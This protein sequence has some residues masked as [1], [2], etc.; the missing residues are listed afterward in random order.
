MCGLSFCLGSIADPRS[1]R[2]LTHAVLAPAPMAS[3]LKCMEPSFCTIL[4]DNGV[5]TEV[6]AHLEEKKVYSMA[7]LANCVDSRSERLPLVLIEPVRSITG[8]AFRETKTILTEL[9]READCAE[10][11]RMQRK[12]QG[13]AEDDLEDPLPKPIVDGL[14]GKHSKRYGYELTFVELLCEPLLG[15]IKR[16]I[17][18]N[19]HSLIII[20]KV[21]NA[22]ENSR[23]A[24]GKRIKM[25]GDVTVT[26]GTA[27]LPKGPRTVYG[28]SI[29]V[30][31]LEILFLGGYSVVGNFIDSKPSEVY[32]PMQDLREYFVMV[33]SKASPLTGPW[34]KLESVRS[35]D[36]GTRALWAEKM[37]KG[38]TMGQAIRE[39]EPKAAA[40]WLFACEND[41]SQAR[42]DAE[43]DD[44][45]DDRD[46]AKRGGGAK[47]FSRDQRDFKRGRDDGGN[48]SGGYGSGGSEVC[49]ETR[50]GKQICESWNV[51]KCSSKCPK[52][53]AHVCNAMLPSG[54]ACGSNSHQRIEGH[55][56]RRR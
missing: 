21:R 4:E 17:D 13:I 43:L 5:P 34:P 12:A 42:D 44:E 32:A 27:G 29:Y 48:G 24:A 9:W 37:R 46:A 30:Q 8:S 1:T 45:R 14:L 38:R 36:E 28:T 47:P 52:N 51:G 2:Y 50:T 35:A 18:R 55:Q 7:R 23:T 16:E 3:V 19:L 54:D 20:E 6:I 25:P 15:R 49:R 56:K 26:V 10:T 41:A 39:S 33:R 11:L 53:F 40:L 31:L 22:K